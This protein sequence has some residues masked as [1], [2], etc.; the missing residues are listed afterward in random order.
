[1]RCAYC[2]YEDVSAN[3]ECASMGIMDRQTTRALIDRTMC[4]DVN[5]INYCFQGGEPTVAGI[6]YFKDFIDYVDRVNTG[7]KITYAIQTNATLLD[8]A[9][10]ELFSKHDFLVGV[11]LDGF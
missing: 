3:R 7:K 6:D 2:F 5:Q 8:D 9:W 1:M 11:S 10:I 4:L